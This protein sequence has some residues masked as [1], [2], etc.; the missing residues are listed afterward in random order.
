[1]AEPRRETR[2]IGDVAP[3][4]YDETLAFF[5]GR[6]D[7]A[8][9]LDRRTITMYQDTRA[10]LAAA[11]DEREVA[12]VLPCLR[13]DAR[14]TRVLDVGCGV[15][16]WGGH[17]AGRVAGYVG[18]DFSPGLI[19]LASEDLAD[20]YPD[21]S[22]TATVLSAT[23]LDR[24]GFESASFDL[25]IVS[26]VMVY[27]NDEDC[28]AMLRTIAGLTAPGGQIY[29]REP[30][31]RTERLTLRGHWSDELAADYSAVYRSVATY[32]ALFAEHLDGCT[33]TAA[34]EL[35]PEL[36]NRAETAQF[37]RLHERTAT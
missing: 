6:A 1:M 4:D 10:A 8:G 30:M 26:G 34:F 20:W 22:G 16:R 2:V 19:R 13:L 33:P 12:D 31:A 17:L 24:G 15:A 35:A 18:L 3:L 5:E 28:A 23:E 21:G 29:I 37:V 36:A 25:V 14:Q 32:D 9:D 27:L 7:R 11:R